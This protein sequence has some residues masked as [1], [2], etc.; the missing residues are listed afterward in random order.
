MF[1]FVA[2]NRSC[3]H[4]DSMRLSEL[5]DTLKT[6]GCYALDRNQGH[7][8]ADRDSDTKANF[9][10]IVALSPSMYKTL[11]KLICL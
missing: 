6:E 11:S 7:S 10:L 1:S 2:Y 9:H 3:I 4:S 8:I 5:S